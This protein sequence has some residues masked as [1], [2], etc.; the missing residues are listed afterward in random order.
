MGSLFDK[1]LSSIFCILGIEL[2]FGDLKIIDKVYYIYRV[3]VVEF[4]MEGGSWKN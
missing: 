2:N 3:N 4:I 1:Y